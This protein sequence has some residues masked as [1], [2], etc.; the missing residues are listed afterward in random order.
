LKGLIVTADDFGAA[1]EVNEAVDIAHREGVLT[2]ASLMVAGPAAADAVVRAR[3]LGSLR[4]GLHLVLVEGTP[5]LP[6]SDIPDMVDEEGLLRTDMGR[7]GAAVFMRRSVRRQLAAE[8]T[9]QFESFRRTGLPLDH[10]TIHKHFHLHPTVADLVL[11]I[12]KAYGV[13][14]VRVPLEP[15]HVLVRA[16]PGARHVSALPL[17][18]WIALLRR[19]VRAAGAFSARQTFGLAWSGAM[20]G[21]RVTSLVGELPLGVSEIYLHPAVRGGFA[22]ACPTYRYADELAGLIDPALREGIERSGARLGGFA[23]FVSA[24]G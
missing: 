11:A 10:V 24:P 20:I 3:R 16:E 22:R 17:S 13:R 14:A 1:I 5:A 15:Q 18:P 23:D 8:I 19:K 9:A 2:T 6:P 21:A 12:G 7:L 4:V